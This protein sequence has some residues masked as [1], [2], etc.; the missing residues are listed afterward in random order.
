MR[1]K[2]PNHEHSDEIIIKAITEASLT[3]SYEEKLDVVFN[4]L[5]YPAILKPLKVTGE[6]KRRCNVYPTTMEEE[7]LY[8]TW[9]KNYYKANV[10]PS[11]ICELEDKLFECPNNE[12]KLNFLRHEIKLVHW[13]LNENDNDVYKLAFEKEKIKSTSFYPHF[14]SGKNNFKTAV[15]NTDYNL[16][17]HGATLYHY[18]SYITEKINVIQSGESD[19]IALSSLKDLKHSREFALLLWE[20]GIYDGLKERYKGQTEKNI[21][22][23]LSYISKQK[24][25]N[26]D[27]LNIDFYNMRVLAGPKENR[28]KIKADSNPFK[29]SSEVIEVLTKL[30][31]PI[32]KIP[33]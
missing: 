4:L 22:R 7:Q 19:E 10:L 25:A 12:Q 9:I 21:C 17:A 8:Y 24:P 3:E 30:R 16:A 26:Q 29:Y 27:T 15:K 20:T 18:I 11:W 14:Y 31:F 2:E 23:L 32:M 13:D 5:G 6:I 1:Y 28:P 33:R